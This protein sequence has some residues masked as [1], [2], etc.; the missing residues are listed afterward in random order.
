MREVEGGQRDAVGKQA[1]EAQGRQHVGGDVGLADHLVSVLTQAGAKGVEPPS[2]SVGA[3]GARP[4]G[5][6]TESSPPRSI[7]QIV[8]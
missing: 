4:A 5:Q 8:S 1:G 3:A 6:A 2:G 7:C